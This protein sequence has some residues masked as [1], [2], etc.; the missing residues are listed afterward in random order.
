M[1]VYAWISHVSLN[2][3]AHAHLKHLAPYIPKL[4]PNAQMMILLGSDMIWV[5]KVRHKV[6]VCV[7]FYFDLPLS[8]RALNKHTIYPLETP[9]TSL[10][11]LHPSERE[12]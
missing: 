4:D 7:L 6:K 8:V 3:L 9:A 12:Q 1:E 2:A 11:S 10:P 5:H